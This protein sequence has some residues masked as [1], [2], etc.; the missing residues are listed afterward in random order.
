MLIQ[1]QIDISILDRPSAKMRARAY[2]EYKHHIEKK[3]VDQ[4]GMMLKINK[5]LYFFICIF[6]FFLY[7]R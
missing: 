6:G 2:V 7:T 5:I 4:Q 1:Q 3:I